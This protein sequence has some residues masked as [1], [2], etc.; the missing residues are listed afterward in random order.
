MAP[1]PRSLGVSVTGLGLLSLRV[2]SQAHLSWGNV[3]KYEEA[4]KETWGKEA[5]VSYGS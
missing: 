3:K 1:N 4:L 2:G 5:L